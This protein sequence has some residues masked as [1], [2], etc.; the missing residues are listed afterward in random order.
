MASDI[1]A[2]SYYTRMLLQ[3]ITKEIP[4]ETGDGFNLIKFHLLTHMIEEDIINYGLPRNISG[5]AG[6]SQ[7]KHNF[8]LPASTT[9]KRDYSFDE[10]VSQRR[11]EHVTIDR[12]M[13][14][15][16]RI[17]KRTSDIENQ[18]V[19]PVHFGSCMRKTTKGT[20]E[21][22]SR[23]TLSDSAYC[24][25]VV[26]PSSKP[27][28]TRV[29]L[30]YTGGS[31]SIRAASFPGFDDP[32]EFFLGVDDKP[33]GLPGTAGLCAY[34]D[35]FSAISYFLAPLFKFDKFLQ[36]K[37]YSK[38][39]VPKGRYQE[40]DVMY[41]A[42]P[43]CQIGNKE[44]HD[45]ALVQWD[46]DDGQVPCQIYTFLDVDEKLMEACNSTICSRSNM[47][48]QALPP[49]E[50]TGTYA[51]VCSLS[52][53]IPGLVDPSITEHKQEDIMQM[54]SIIFFYGTK[55]TD[56]DK[57]L[58]IRLVLVESFIRP[59][60]VVPDFDPT[61]YNNTSGLTVEHWVRSEERRNS[62]IVVRPR[63]H[64]HLAFLALAKK[65]YDQQSSR[66]PRRRKKS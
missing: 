25:A 36:I 16:A 5:S 41:R 60:I 45:W 65:S 50:T 34:N 26:H 21:P 19:L 64:W 12:C 44:R 39:K 20:I 62:V 59:L 29:D 51:V 54:N 37:I 2:V 30:V 63:D 46:D 27:S 9:Q 15:L 66:T 48:E 55:E 42:D 1:P 14:R 24:V 32:K 13:Q 43:C 47:G 11:H 3:S 33:I 22:L 38:L 53:E 35:S 31:E 6:E 61:F 28:A 10:Q 49:L 8:K 58:V 52:K 17:D 18:T 4:Q 23:P 57:H 7:F 40:A 56:R